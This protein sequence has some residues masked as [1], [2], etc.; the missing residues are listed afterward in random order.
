MTAA[1]HPAFDDLR[2]RLVSKLSLLRPWKGAAYRVTT[3][4]YPRPESILLGQGSFLHG[5]RWNAIGSVRAVYGSTADTVAVAESRA[6]ADY[7]NIPGPF[8]TPRLLVAIDVSLQAVLD[9]TEATTCAALSL[10]AAD[11]RVEDWRKIQE[12]GGE[13]F[14]QAIGRAVFSA[15]GEG[16]LVPSARVPDGVNVVYFPEN[17]RASSRV[18]VFEAEELRRIQME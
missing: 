6:T 15:K 9:L 18:R 7:A 17:L 12:D 4:S 11:L 3:L 5:G 13:S 14:T 2:R 8:R 10:A 16:L 1:P